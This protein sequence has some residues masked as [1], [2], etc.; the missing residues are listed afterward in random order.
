[1]YPLKRLEGIKLPV[2]YEPSEHNLLIKYG[3]RIRIGFLPDNH[4]FS[5]YDGI[6]YGLLSRYLAHNP[7]SRVL[8]I[9]GGYD[10]IAV[11]QMT[12]QFPYAT[13]VNIDLFAENTSISK[14]GNAS[15]LPIEDS[16]IDVVVSVHCVSR[17][18]ISWPSEGHIMVKETER[19][20]KHD[21]II[22][23]SPGFDLSSL[24]KELKPVTQLYG[25]NTWGTVHRKTC[26]HYQG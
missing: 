13:A 8:D 21:G 20:L 22:F 15:S 10:S 26:M 6:F 23:L 1:M 16:S 2:G 17:F 18:L 9:G 4:G 7:A 12:E 19:V 5:G 11:K 25:K 14:Q 3:K 24:S